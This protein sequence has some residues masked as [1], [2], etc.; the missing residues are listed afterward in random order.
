M[1]KKARAPVNLQPDLVPRPLWRQSAYRKLGR[2]KD[3]RCIRQ[4]T[5]EASG[6][7]C[8]ACGAST[9]PLFCHEKWDYN[10]TTNT[11]TLVGFEMLCDPCN[12]AVHIGLA[13]L[14]G[15]L[16]DARAQLARVNRMTPPEVRALIERATQDWKRRSRMRWRIAI[17]HRLLEAYPQ[18]RA[19]A[20]TRRK[21]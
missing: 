5:L 7:R 3:W 10:E 4:D 9:P 2:G 16:Q 17:K 18:L 12:W 6:S 20:A 13:G 11:A 1:R 14:R 15:H 19:F 21:D 8:E